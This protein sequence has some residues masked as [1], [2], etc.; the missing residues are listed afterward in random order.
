[1]G[2]GF[3]IKGNL[4]AKND[5]ENQCAVNIIKKTIGKNPNFSLRGAVES[6]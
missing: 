4:L 2:L 5:I 6:P 1:V 3:I